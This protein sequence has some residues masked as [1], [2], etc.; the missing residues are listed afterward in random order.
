MSIQQ[1]ICA[2][3]AGQRLH[4][5][6]AILIR[7]LLKYVFT[8][9]FP[10]KPVTKKQSLKQTKKYNGQANFNCCWCRCYC[11]WCRRCSRNHHFI[12][13]RRKGQLG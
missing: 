5:N 13:I 12:S 6:R 3:V 7:C 1:L 2:V 11:C 9:F 8:L 10:V 4:I